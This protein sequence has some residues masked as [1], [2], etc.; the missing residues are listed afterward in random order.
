MKLKYGN[1]KFESIR[2]KSKLLPNSKPVTISLPTDK[3]DIVKTKRAIMPNFIDSLD[4]VN[5]HILLNKLAE[6]DK[7]KI[8]VYTI[9]DCFATTPNNMVL[10]EHLLKTHLLKYIL[11]IKGI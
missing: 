2:T 4:T 9:H 10:L 8:S 11:K 3:I 7:K 6:E 1:I 5:V